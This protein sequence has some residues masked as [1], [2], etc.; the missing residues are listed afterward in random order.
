ME[1]PCCARCLSASLHLPHSAAPHAPLPSR[2]VVAG[3]S[4]TAVLATAITSTATFM[5]SGCVDPA[6]S[7][8]VCAPAVLLAPVGARLASRLDC[9]A[10]RRMLGYFLVLAAPLI[11]LKAWMFSGR[12]EQQAQQA[13]QVQQQPLD[14]ATKGS[15]SSGGGGASSSSTG[16]SDGSSPGSDPGTSGGSW[17]EQLRQRLPRPPVAAGL[18]VAGGAAGFA[19]GLL[20]IGGGTVGEAGG[21]AGGAQAP[22][23]KGCGTSCIS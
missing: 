10:L 3:T 12:G 21:V 8:L 14:H 20:G 1:P 22:A 11:P 23:W 2:R 15:N 16:G 17:A 9:A 5:A 19:S 6:A 7:A 4:L 18:L 13:Q